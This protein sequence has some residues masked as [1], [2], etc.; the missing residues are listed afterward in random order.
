MADSVQDFVNEVTEAQERVADKRADVASAL[1]EH[2]LQLPGM[3]DI[4]NTDQE[5]QMFGMQITNMVEMAARQKAE[6]ARM[7][8]P[9]P[10]PPVEG[11]G[12]GQAV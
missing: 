10:L 11:N 9:A 1:V 3:S 2:M 4:F 7:P 8:E 12:G 5:K 6:Q